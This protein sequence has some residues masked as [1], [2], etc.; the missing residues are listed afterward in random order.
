MNFFLIVGALLFGAKI[1]W[2]LVFGA[3][4]VYEIFWKRRR[5]PPGPAP[6]LL[7][8]NMPS[9][10]VASSIDELFLN[11]KRKFGPIFTVWI[12]PIPLVMVC[13]LTTIRKYFVQNADAFSNRW[14]NFITDSIMG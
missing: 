6:W 11:W 9:F 3:Y 8:G 2:T 7:A 10:V 5:L 4:V 1:S 13:D 12:G 14:R